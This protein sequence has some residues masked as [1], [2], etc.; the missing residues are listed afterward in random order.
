[1]WEIPGPCH[2]SFYTLNCISLLQGIIIIIIIIIIITES[3]EVNKIPSCKCF[4]L[5]S[6]SFIF[7]GRADVRKVKT[8]N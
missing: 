7:D 8:N 4:H 6:A 3:L 5:R 1:M 2:D